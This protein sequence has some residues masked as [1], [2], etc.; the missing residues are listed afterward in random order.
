VMAATDRVV[1]LN[2]HVCCSGT[3]EAVSRNPE[4]L[5]LFGV[6]PA[7]A[8]AVYAHGHGH[9]HAHDLAADPPGKTAHG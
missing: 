5:A 4:Y 7:E 2:R 6:Q 8:V 9:D 3:P 1:C